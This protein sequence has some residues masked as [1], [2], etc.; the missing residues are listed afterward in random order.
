ML[1]P[2]PSAQVARVAELRPELSRDAAGGSVGAAASA[3]RNGADPAPSSHEE[4][5]RCLAILGETD[6]ATRASAAEGRPDQRPDT[7]SSAG[8][9]RAAASSD[10]QTP[11]SGSFDLIG[12]SI[13]A[14]PAAAPVSGGLLAFSPE[15]VAQSA[16]NPFEQPVANG[17]HGA[18]SSGAA[19][20][21]A[22][23]P[24]LRILAG[25][26]RLSRF[27]PAL[28]SHETIA[29]PGAA[30]P[31]DV[32]EG[33]PGVLVHALRARHSLL[34]ALHARL[35][36]HFSSTSARGGDDDVG[37]LDDTSDSGQDMDDDGAQPWQTVRRSHTFLCPPSARE[38]AEPTRPPP[39]PGERC[40][41]HADCYRAA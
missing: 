33:S 22:L 32:P 38:R 29:L 13:D 12:L 34:A 16:P 21:A 10:V 8:P 27:E 1:T 4:W 30:L 15:A 11:R 40:Q 39:S 18:S 19:S 25:S 14:S 35:D 41:R 28:L 37:A 26:A 6:S 5:E 17:G 9:E 2:R 31:S 3:R 23:E 24:V 20:S 7:M 36:V